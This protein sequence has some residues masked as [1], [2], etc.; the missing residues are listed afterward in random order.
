M[1]VKAQL[2]PV[3]FL[4][5]GPEPN[6][7]QGRQALSVPAR[8]SACLRPYGFMQKSIPARS[9]DRSDMVGLDIFHESR[10]K[11]TVTLFFCVTDRT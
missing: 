1:G 11:G 8:R 6:M 3:P 2:V 5:A 4:P 7:V 10:I 9:R